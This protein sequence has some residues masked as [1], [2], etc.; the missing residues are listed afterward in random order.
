MRDIRRRAIVFLLLAGC[1]SAQ[2]GGSKPT[3]R[4]AKIE[5]SRGALAQRIETALD[6]TAASRNAFWGIQAVDLATNKTLYELNPNRYFVP[7]SNTKLFSSALALTLLGPDL[8]F[9]TRILADAAPD[10]DGLVGGSLRFIAGGDPN[11]SARAI[12]YAKGPGGSDPLIAIEDLATQ[13]AAKGVKHVAGD[14]IGDDSYYVWQP[15]ADGWSVQDPEGK[16]GAAVSAFSINDNAFAITFLPGAAT[17]DAAV[18]RLNPALPYYEIENRIRTIPAGG[19]RRIHSDRLAGSLQLHVWGT[20]PLGDRGQTIEFGIDDP[21]L[22]AAAALRQA[23]ADRGITV[24]GE[25]RAKHL[26]PEDVA[27]LRRASAPPPIAGVE[28]ADR[29]SAPLLECLRVTAKVSENL[30]AEMMLR[31]VGRA[32]RNIGSREAGLDELR[33]FLAAAGISADDYHLAD[34]SGMARLNLV[35]P[36]AVVRLLQHMY[37]SPQRE[38][39]LAILP[40]GG[41]DGTLA[42]RF[43]GAA[44]TGR[45]HAKTGT[46][47]HVSALSGYAQRPDK[48]WVAFS[49][50]V[51]NFNGAAG[52]VRKVMDEVCGFI[53]E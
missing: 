27:D 25:A 4:I 11:L 33:T 23:L 41:E 31:A 3:A 50:L 26:L 5:P 15:Y 14:I 52:D 38:D 37:A 10:A 48:S 40:V 36:S 46:L 45:V 34:G 9:H 32:R 8:K 7:A 19:E 2:R 6:S 22:Y 1:A 28:L 29:E 51:N 16:D 30:H 44:V 12:P 21:A 17:G 42:S 18:L 13:V 47:A 53:M 39:F 35:T 49:I 24:D 43:T 20:I